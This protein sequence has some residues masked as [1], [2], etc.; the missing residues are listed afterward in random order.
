MSTKNL[1]FAIMLSVFAL[2]G[3]VVYHYGKLYDGKFHVIFCDVGQ[4]DAI[5]LRTPKGED[6]LVDG[7][8]NHDV[9]A[10]LSS[11]M[12]FWDRDLELVILTHP[13]ADHLNGLINVAKRYK[14]ISFATEN[15]KNNTLI[16]EALM[17]ELENQ[18]IKIQ[19]LYAGDRFLFKDGV[20]LNIIGP[21]RRFLKQ[22]SPT[23]MIGEK[24]E[25]GNIVS[26]FKYKDF[27]VLLTGDSQA[28][29][30]KEAILGGGLGGIDVIQVPHHGSKTGLDSEIL[31]SIKSEL[32]VISVSK[33]N[34]YGHPAIGIIEILRD[35]DIKILRTDERGEIEIVTNGVDWGVKN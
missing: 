21:S 13:H 26:L 10:C 23:G 17:K 20:S 18:N 15:V 22:T 9:L 6:I 11:H 2:L 1:I 3:I 24:S 16:F 28:S 4:G 25:F 5:F 27:S 30:L 33:K 12:P 29:Q 14:I 31:D 32:A 34:K 35:K 8:P 7:G 19:H